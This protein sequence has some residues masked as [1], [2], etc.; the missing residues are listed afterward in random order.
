MKANYNKQDIVSALS[1]VGIGEGDDVFIHSNLGFY[2]VLEGCKSADDLCSTF[3][4]AIRDVIG[5]NGTIICPTFS[6][7]YCH[8]EVYNPTTTGTTCGM[9]SEYLIRNYPQNRTLDPNFS[10]CG[11]G[12]RMEEYK[13]CNIHEAFGKD[14]F[15]E[16]FM[17]HNGKILC[18]NF[19]AG[20]TFVHYIERANNVSYRYNKAFNGQTVVA[21]RMYRDYAVHF[22]FEGEDDGPCMERVDELCRANAIC[23]ETTLG[24]G[25]VLASPSKKYFEFFSKLLVDR[26]RVLC[27]R[28]M[29]E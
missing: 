2:G 29:I 26:P 13:S 4:E 14:C 1:A 21:D 11:L 12:G 28:E 15:F 27:K 10:V 9:L 18:L 7:S 22:V 19:D 8:N 23:K 25:T 3:I 24:R 16:R 17:S 6:Y 5:E 20:S